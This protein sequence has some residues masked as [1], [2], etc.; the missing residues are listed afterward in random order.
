MRM[1]PFKSTVETCPKCLETN[2]FALCWLSAQQEVEGLV[3][4][5]VERMCH[6]CPSCTWSYY[7]LPADV[8]S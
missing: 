1:P 7:S 5:D 8:V 6:R 3:R 2:R 4:G